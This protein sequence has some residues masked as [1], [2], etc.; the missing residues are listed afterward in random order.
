MIERIKISER[1]IGYIE[2]LTNIV[3]LAVVIGSSIAVFGKCNIFAN[4][5][6]QRSIVINVLNR[7]I[8]RI[9]GMNYDAVL[10]LGTT[11]TTAEL[12]QLNNATGTLIL[13]DPFFNS[14]IRRVTVTVNWT[15]PEGRTLTKNLSALISRIG[16]SS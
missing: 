16:V 8:E 12:S 6:R 1:G 10:T 3:V 7:E 4:E 9:R 5:I 15:S 14:N 11:F 13:D 2:I